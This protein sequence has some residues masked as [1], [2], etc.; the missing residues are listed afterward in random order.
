MNAHGE[1]IILDSVL[2]LHP[3]FVNFSESSAM[4]FGCWHFGFGISSMIH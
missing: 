2:N 4:L 3:D 1:V